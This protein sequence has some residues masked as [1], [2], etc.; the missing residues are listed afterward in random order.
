MRSGEYP[1]R[2]AA[3]GPPSAAAGAQPLPHN[4]RKQRKIRPQ[5]DGESAFAKVSGGSDAT[6]VERSLSHKPWFSHS[7]P[8]DL[9]GHSVQSRQAANRMNCR[10]DG[11]LRNKMD[12]PLRRHAPGKRA[13]RD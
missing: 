10:S 9:S 5:S 7:S 12:P 2:E 6:G 13:L 3:F 4:P 1:L 11:F 8:D